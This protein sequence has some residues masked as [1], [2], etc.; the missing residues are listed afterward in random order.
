[1]GQTVLAMVFDC[2]REL[3]SV[4][5][6]DGLEIGKDFFGLGGNAG[7][8]AFRKEDEVGNHDLRLIEAD[9]VFAFDR[10]GL[11]MA[12]DVHEFSFGKESFG[13]VGKGTPADAVSVFGF[14]KGF[15]SGV[16]EGT[17]GRDGEENDFSV[18]L[19]RFYEG[20]LR[21]VSYE[22]DLVYGSHGGNRREL[23]VET[24]EH[25]APDCLAEV[26]VRGD[27]LERA[28]V[29]IEVVENVETGFGSVDLVRELLCSPNVF[30]NSGYAVGGKF[31]LHL[32]KEG[33]AVVVRE[34]RVDDH[35]KFVFPH[36]L[37]ISIL[38]SGP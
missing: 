6:V 37:W 38:R 25:V 5:E 4:V 22:N 32:G 30:G 19:G 8:F 14:G 34:G 1:M 12:F 27:G 7:V 26:E 10:A 23:V 20:I 29:G 35:H 36:N 33:G 3:E 21:D 2:Y 28:S 18:S 24:D 9:S 31:G 15:S 13:S 11:E 16:L 17:V